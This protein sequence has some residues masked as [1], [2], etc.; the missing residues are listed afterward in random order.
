VDI[1]RSSS[2][3]QERI[4][5]QHLQDEAMGLAC[6]LAARSDLD[7][8]TVKQAYRLL[9][10]THPLDQVMR[11]VVR[12]QNRP[13]KD[14][15]WSV[16]DEINEM[17]NSVIVDWRENTASRPEHAS[18]TSAGDGSAAQGWATTILRQVLQQGSL[19]VKALC[20]LDPDLASETSEA[21]PVSGPSGDTGQW[22]AR[23]PFLEAWAQSTWKSVQDRYLLLGILFGPRALLSQL[24][25]MSSDEALFSAA[26][27]SLLDLNSLQP[28]DRSL[29][30]EVAEC[31][32]TMEAPQ[33]SSIFS[34]W[35]GVLGMALHSSPDE[36][37]WMDQDIFKK[38]SGELIKTIRWAADWEGWRSCI[39]DAFWALNIIYTNPDFAEA[40]GSNVEGLR[41]IAESVKAK[42]ND[43]VQAHK[44]ADK[45][46]SM[47]EF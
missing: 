21:L 31:L 44:Q 35:V 9:V 40:R 5:T 37:A 42:L 7:H 28:F 12:H 19:G 23:L 17:L 43:E 39:Q 20:F 8:D 18:T 4:I 24:R 3:D 45:L 36:E 34:A 30:R 10:H 6:T 25:P 14:M 38:A 22:S 33:S 11:F 32:L 46:L 41:E 26:C 2:G 27:R 16:L 1:S 13:W 47:L 15:L 29:W